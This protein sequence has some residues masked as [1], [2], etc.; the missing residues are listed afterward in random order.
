MFLDDLFEH[1]RGAG[2]VPDGFWIDHCDRALE[3]NA[4]AICFGAE[5][6]RFRIGEAQLFEA[7]LEVVPGDQAVLFGAALRFGLVG[8]KEDVPCVFLQPQGFD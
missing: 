4:E 5:H 2:V 7:G 1:V 3:A 6:E 8:T